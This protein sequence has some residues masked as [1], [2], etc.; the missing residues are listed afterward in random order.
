[1]VE[2]ELH[3]SLSNTSVGLPLIAGDSEDGSTASVVTVK[4]EITKE[5]I[6]R[7]DPRTESDDKPFLPKVR[8]G[9]HLQ[10]GTWQ[11]S[12]KRPKKKVPRRVTS[13]ALTLAYAGE[14]GAS[15]RAARDQIDSQI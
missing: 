14:G 2:Q 7:H 11:P 12:E 15:N 4:E 10:L 8:G 6:S 13:V 1:M 3:S 5:I 9:L